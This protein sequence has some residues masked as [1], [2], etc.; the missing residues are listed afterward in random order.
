MIKGAV[1]V[2]LINGR[3][4]GKSTELLHSLKTGD[5]VIFTNS[6]EARR[7]Q[8]LANELG[9]EIETQVVSPSQPYKLRYLGT[10]KGNLVFD[11]S[12]VEQFYM[13]AIESAQQDIDYFQR[14][15]S[16]YGMAHVETRMA[17]KE[18]AKWQGC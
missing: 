11:H 17:A 12:W 8:S 16:G 6:K 3:R 4:S 13:S 15:L 7:I 18:R 5:R 9:V 10:P 2:L 14:E 1:N